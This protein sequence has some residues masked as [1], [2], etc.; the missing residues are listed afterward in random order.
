MVEDII[1]CRAFPAAGDRARSSFTY[2][3]PRRGCRELAESRRPLYAGRGVRQ[4]ATLRITGQL[5]DAGSGTH[6]RPIATKAIDDVFDLRIASPPR[7]RGDHAADG[8]GTARTKSKRRAPWTPTTYL[9]LRG[10]QGR[11][12]AG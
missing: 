9:A 1:G 7:R 11:S 4:G 8:G 6:R 2:K 10:R 12:P 3:K 5:I